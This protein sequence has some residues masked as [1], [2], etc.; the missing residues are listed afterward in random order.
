M[1][2][3]TVLVIVLGAMYIVAVV[4]ILTPIPSVSSV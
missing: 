4:Y 1:T 2:I 3:E